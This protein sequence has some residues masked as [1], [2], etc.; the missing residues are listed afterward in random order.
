MVFSNL[1]VFGLSAKTQK[2]IFS[3]QPYCTVGFFA[4][5]KRRFPGDSNWGEGKGVGEGDRYVEKSSEGNF[6]CSLL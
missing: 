5:L 2:G 1:F 6:Y 4:N 3:F